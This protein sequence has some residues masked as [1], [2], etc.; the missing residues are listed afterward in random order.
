MKNILKRE[1][2]RVPYIQFFRT[3]GTTL[4]IGFELS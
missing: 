2:Y 4:V 1:K 3:I